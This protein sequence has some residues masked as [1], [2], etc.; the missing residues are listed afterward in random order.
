MFS[1]G[2]A[3]N[4]HEMIMSEIKDVESCLIHFESFMHAATTPE[5]VYETLMSLAEVVRQAEDT[6]D[7]SLRRMI[8]SLNGN[9]LPSTREQI[10]AEMLEKYDAPE[11]VLAADVDKVLTSLRGIGAIDE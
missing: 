8:D 7:K 2:K 10:I 11:A 5:T 1:K 3:N 9:F 6:A 4:V